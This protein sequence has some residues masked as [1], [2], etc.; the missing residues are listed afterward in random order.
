MSDTL[1]AQGAG[2]SVG[3]HAATKDE[4]IAEVAFTKFFHHTR[5]QREVRSAE[6]RQADS[7]DIFLQGRLG[8]L[9]RGLMQPRVD[10]FETMIAKGARDGLRA[11]IMPIEAGLGNNNTVGPLH[12]YRTLGALTPFVTTDDT[13]T[14]NEYPELRSGRLAG[15]RRPQLRSPFARAVVPVLGGLAFF[16]ALGLFLWGIAVFISHN[17][18]TTA[19]GFA[20]SVFE[21][22][23]TASL[24][25]VIDD[26][27]SLMLPD[28]LNSS[29]RLTIVL[30]HTGD[31]EKAN[32]TISMAYPADRDV[33]CKVAQI[34]KTH[35]FTDC[36]GRT[37]GVA[38][39]AVPP[40]G[41]KLIVWPDGR[42]T[43]SL[44]TAEGSVPSPTNG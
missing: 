33:N 12:E 32:W 20:P 41:V 31:V 26:G 19:S 10:D 28:L 18:G 4:C 8:D 36:E 21:A 16:A 42:L 30:D 3:D 40:S 14:C 5:K 9:F 39:L 27:G 34:K 23:N 6:Q 35:Q 11:P 44:R 25:G 37:L 17:S 2:I 1:L 24:A 15:M 38:D 43:I 29:G 22:G 13:R 7:V